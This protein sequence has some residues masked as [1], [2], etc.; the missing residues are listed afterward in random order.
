MFRLY[1]LDDTLLNSEIALIALVQ[2][3]DIIVESNIDPID[4]AR[5]LCSELMISDD[6]YKKIKDKA[7]RDSSKERLDTI[8]DEIKDRVKHDAGILNK[9]VNILRKG[10]DRNDLADKIIIKVYNV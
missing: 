6:F 9:F 2:C 3:T 7:S 5:K 1:A 4:L 10:L 8:L